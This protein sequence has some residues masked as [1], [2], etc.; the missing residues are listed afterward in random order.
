LLG[1]I[2]QF[3]TTNRTNL[4]NLSWDDNPFQTTEDTEK[5]EE[6]HYSDLSFG[7]FPDH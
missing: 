7:A 5:M 4:A 2:I 3:E 6:H 1:L